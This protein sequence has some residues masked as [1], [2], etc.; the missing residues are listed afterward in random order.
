MLLEDTRG[1]G[2]RRHL[3]KLYADPVSG[4][5][6]WGL[7]RQADGS[8]IGVYSQSTDRP[9]RRDGFVMGSLQIPAA[10]RYQDWKFIAKVQ[11]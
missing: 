6:D 8:I 11:Q 2:L 5:R 10:D 4:G 1:G 9:L 7:V 3:R